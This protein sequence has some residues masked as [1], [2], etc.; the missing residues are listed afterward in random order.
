MCVNVFTSWEDALTLSNLFELHLQKGSV[1]CM[2]LRVSFSSAVRVRGAFT[3][4]LVDVGVVSVY[5]VLA[6]LCVL[7]QV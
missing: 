5:V 3:L 1:L 4:S 2:S 7:L 6:V